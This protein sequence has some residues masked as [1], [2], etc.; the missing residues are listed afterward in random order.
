MKIEIKIIYP[1]LNSASADLKYS[2]EGKRNIEKN[3]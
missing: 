1:N 2:H 3:L